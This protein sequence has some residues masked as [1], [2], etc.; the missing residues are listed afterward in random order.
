LKIAKEK[1]EWTFAKHIS[2]DQATSI[3]YKAKELGIEIRVETMY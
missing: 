2:Y 3:Y 1:S